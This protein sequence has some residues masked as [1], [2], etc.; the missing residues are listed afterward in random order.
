MKNKLENCVK[1]GGKFE[2]FW[3]NILPLFYHSDCFQIIK[4]GLILYNNTA[5]SKFWFHQFSYSMVMQ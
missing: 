3:P 4:E 1:L 5:Q 2:K